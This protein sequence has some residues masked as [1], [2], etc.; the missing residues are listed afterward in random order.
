MSDRYPGGLIRKT[1][2]TVVGPTDGEGGS[3]PGIWT[4]EEVAANEKA[5]T[6]PKPVLPKELYTWG[7][8]NSGQLGQSLPTTIDLSSLASFVSFLKS[9]SPI[10]S[11]FG[12]S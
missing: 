1:P 3:A 12:I 8:N 4:L 5:G 7:D 11:T 2:P 9:A 6:W 10:S